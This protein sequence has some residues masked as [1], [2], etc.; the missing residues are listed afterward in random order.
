MNGKL[1]P[2][3]RTSLEIKPREF[4][5][6]MMRNG[7]SRSD[8]KKALRKLQSDEVFVNDTYQ[9]NID[10]SASH[11]FPSWLVVVHLSIK[12]RD[13]Q[14]FDDWRDIQAIKNVLLGPE[15]EALELYP[16]EA[17]LVDTANQRHLWAF[18]KA[19]QGSEL[20]PVRAPLGW[21]GPREV[22][23]D[24]RFGAVQRALS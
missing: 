17:R 24:G 14:A 22:C 7:F 16:S 8:A 6:E 18:A 19:G 5:S 3:E 11:G 13:K 9:V 1:A 2:F 20:V 21:T 10:R 12:R 23:G 15:F 4:L